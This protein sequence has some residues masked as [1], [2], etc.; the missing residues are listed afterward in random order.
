MP[1]RIWSDEKDD[2]IVVD[3]VVNQAINVEVL[4]GKGYYRNPKLDEEGNPIE[5]EFSDDFLSVEECLEKIGDKM[6]SGDIGAIGAIKDKVDD[7]EDRVTYIEENGGGGGGNANMPTV[8]LLSENYYAIPTDG[9]VTIYYNFTS[10]NIGFGTA[11]IS[12]DYETV[13]SL[14]ISQGQNSYVVKELEKG[15]HRLDIYVT[16]ITGLFS[17]TI[18]VTIVVGGL[19]LTSTFDDSSDISLEDYIRIKYNISTISSTAIGVSIEIDGQLTKTE[20]I[21]GQKV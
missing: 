1:N 11:Y 4:D 19:E 14:S 8:K 6:N 15:E 20:G 10:P 18:T 16:D 2:W 13:G 21:I 7:L 12:I 3:D 9:E 5:G 17:N